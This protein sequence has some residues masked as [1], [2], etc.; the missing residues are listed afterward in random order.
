[1]DE[2]RH[3]EQG[4]ETSG[5]GKRQAH[6]LVVEEYATDQPGSVQGGSN[7]LRSSGHPG[8]GHKGVGK[9]SRANPEGGLVCKS[10]LQPERS[11]LR[12]AVEDGHSWAY[13]CLFVCTFPAHQIQHEECRAF[14][15][16]NTVKDAKF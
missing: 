13:G 16:V 8:N 15:I 12:V 6:L 11:E 4:R 5:H 1:M 2:A 10:L 7:V 3:K 14:S 9:G